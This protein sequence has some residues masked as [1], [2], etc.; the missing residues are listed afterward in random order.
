MEVGR[1]GG[2]ISSELEGFLERVLGGM[3]QEGTEEKTDET[4]ALFIDEIRGFTP[5]L[6]A[7]RSSYDFSTTDD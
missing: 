4:P 5:D 1:G 6:D 2:G 3:V 7:F